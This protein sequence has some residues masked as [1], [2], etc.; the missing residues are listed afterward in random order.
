MY[1]CKCI[2]CIYI[3]GQK[4]SYHEI[5]EHLQVKLWGQLTLWLEISTWT[6]KQSVKTQIHFLSEC[7]SVFLLSIFSRHECQHLHSP[8]ISTNACYVV[9]RLR[10]SESA[11]NKVCTHSFWVCWQHKISARVYSVDSRLRNS[12]VCWQHSM[13]LQIYLG[14]ASPSYTISD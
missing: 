9:S 12:W 2:T 4:F 5:P 11:D 10:I 8:G 14:W 6:L 3:F 7:F 1:I 13:H